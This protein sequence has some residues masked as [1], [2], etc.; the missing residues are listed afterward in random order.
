MMSE[1]GTKKR[2]P[3]SIKKASIKKGPSSSTKKSNCDHSSNKIICKKEDKEEKVDILNYVK[4]IRTKKKVDVNIYNFLKILI[5]KTNIESQAFE[6]VLRGAFVIL[7]DNG[8]IYEQFKNHGRPVEYTDYGPVRVYPS[9]HWSEKSQ[10][11]LGK[12]ELFDQLGNKNTTFDLLVG[13]SIL[14]DFIGNTWFQFENSRIETLAQMVFH[15]KDFIKYVGTDAGNIGAF[16]NSPY[17]ELKQKGPLLVEMCYQLENC[18][19]LK[20]NHPIKNSKKYWNNA[21]MSI[22]DY[23]NL[24]PI[25]YN[26]GNEQDSNP[27]LRYEYTK[28]TLHSVINSVL[29]KLP[30]SIT[31]YKDN[32]KNDD[33]NEDY[34]IQIRPDTLIMEVYKYISN[35]IRAS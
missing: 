14:P 8:A 13:T 9:S 18:L 7:Q 20:D 29:E 1:S 25:I 31:V 35:H 12:G 6:Q 28:R 3:S 30:S 23:K 15:M 17:T 10:Y 24:V 2:P 11:R 4:M 21:K 22:E 26:A 5:M 32:D 16:G 33:D 27:W 34:S 19:F